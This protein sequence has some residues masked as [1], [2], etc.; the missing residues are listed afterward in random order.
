MAVNL[1]FACEYANRLGTKHCFGA[2]TI[3]NNPDRGCECECRNHTFEEGDIR[4]NLIEVLTAG[5]HEDLDLM[6][7]LIASYDSDQ[8]KTL[9][10][11]LVQLHVWMLHQLDQDPIA[12][13]QRAALYWQGG[14]S[15]GEPQTEDDDR[16]E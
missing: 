10:V 7:S 1:C 11:L 3:M 4:F 6:K 13:V 15:D 5:A 2:N 16:S 14:K 9:L 12:T 8:I